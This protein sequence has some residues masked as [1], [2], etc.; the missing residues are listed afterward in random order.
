MMS[1][2]N[3]LYQFM[4]GNQEEKIKKTF[5]N[6]WYFLALGF[7]SGLSPKAP[8]TMGSLVALPFYYLFQ[9][10]GIWVHLGIVVF[11][12]LFGIWLCGKV[13]ED[14]QVKDPSSIVWDEFVGMW[15]T[16]L[17]LPSGLHWLVVAFCLFRLFDILKPW[18]VGWIDKNL[19][20]GAGIMLDDV[21]AGVISL[22][23]IQLANIILV[24][25]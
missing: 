12:T 2:R 5:T 8:G 13:A 17:F 20:G 3:R 6:P 21:A 15:I 10:L 7:G 22:L 9:W 18:P 1:S 11:S 16:L 14:M 4:L 23:I 19:S 25:L 24:T